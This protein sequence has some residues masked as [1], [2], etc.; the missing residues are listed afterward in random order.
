[1]KVLDLNKV[2]EVFGGQSNAERALEQ[3][4][5]MPDSTNVTLQ[6]EIKTNSVELTG[7]KSNNGSSWSATAGDEN[8]S[9]TYNS[10]NSGNQNS[11]SHTTTTTKQSSTVEVNCGDLREMNKSN[12]SFPYHRY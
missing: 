12:D 2:E 8:S 1:M 4:L 9:L 10:G 3:C 5:G 6:N 7:T 11:K